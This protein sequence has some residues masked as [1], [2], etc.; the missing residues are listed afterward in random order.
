MAID[1]IIDAMISIHPLERVPRAGFLLRGVT[2]P[3][4]VAAH[5]HSLAL[6]TLMVCNEYP[7]DF[8]SSK[9]VEMALIHDIQEVQTMDIPLP[10]GS[11]EFRAAKEDTEE[12]IFKR[13]F[14]GVSPALAE[15]YAEF[16]RCDSPEAKLVRGLDKVQMMVKVLCYQRENR[17]Y[18]DAFWE[19]RHNFPDF[20]MPVLKAL[21]EAVARKAGRKPPR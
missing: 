3:E 11:A 9:A 6:L 7:D 17:G 19:H 1:E 2:E 16:R 8:D 18:L 21:F 5:S 20:D 13:L 15:R 14:A 12:E 10:V 4:S